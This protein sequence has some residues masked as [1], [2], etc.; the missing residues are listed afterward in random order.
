MLGIGDRDRGWQQWEKVN[1]MERKISEGGAVKCFC[2]FEFLG[3]QGYDMMIII[4]F[5]LL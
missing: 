3:G 5:I 1:P 2:I 4:T